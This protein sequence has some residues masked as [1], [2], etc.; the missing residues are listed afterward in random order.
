MR[1][2]VAIASAGTLTAA[3]RRLRMPLTTV[4]RVLAALEGHV[5]AT[6]IARTTRRFDL[7]D[8]GREYLEACRRILDDIDSTHARIAGKDL[9]L[10]GELALTAPIVFG[11][12]HILPIVAAFLRAYPKMTARM[13]LVDRVVDLVEEGIDVALRIGALPDTSMIAVRVGGVRITTCASPAYL[14][15]RG[16]PRS[17][18]ALAGHD[19]ITFASAE[20]RDFWIFRRGSELQNV[21]LRSKLSVNTA[22]AAVDAAAAGLGITRLLS[23][24]TQRDIAAG[25]LKAILTRFDDGDVPVHLIRRDGS[26]SQAKVKRFVEFAVPRLRKKLSSVRQAS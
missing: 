8:R 25:R 13:M 26:R 10:S 18:K 11:R 6:L 3:G 1:V 12:L 15:A 5:G 14:K 7:T 9:E 21:R 23:Y 24:Q 2:F 22:E 19:C 17:P 20:S 4:S 16:Q